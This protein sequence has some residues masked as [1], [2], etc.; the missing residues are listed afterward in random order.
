MLAPDTVLQSRY[1]IVRQ[2]GQGGMGAV[3]EAIDQRLKSLVAVKEMLVHSPMIFS[4]VAMFLAFSDWLTAQFSI[5]SVLPI[6]Y[7]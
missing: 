5:H 4:S 7:T 6:S 3:Y 2:L 1:R